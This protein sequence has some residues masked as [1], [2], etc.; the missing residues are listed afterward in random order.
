MPKCDDV[1]KDA[2]TRPAVGVQQMGVRILLLGAFGLASAKLL[3]ATVPEKAP[4]ES[5]VPHLHVHAH[6]EPMVDTA[7]WQIT[8]TVVSNGATAVVISNFLAPSVAA[9]WHATLNATWA[10]AS[11]CRS[12]QSECVAALASGVDGGRCSWLYTTNSHGGN[13]K[14]RSV[15]TRAERREEVTRMYQA[16]SF[17]YSK[18]ELTASHA[19]YHAVGDMMNTHSVRV[20][21]ARAMWPEHAS[22]DTAADHL[23]NI[24]D[25]FITAFDDG[26]FLSTHNDGSSGSLAWVLHLSRD[27]NPTSGGELRFNAG[28]PNTPQSRGTIDFSPGFN[29]MLLFLTRPGNTP[30]EVLPV[31]LASTDAEPRFGL[32]GWYMTSGDAFQGGTAAE[33]AQMKAGE[34]KVSLRG[35]DLCV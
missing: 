33:F 9:H 22:A 6:H 2:S 21:V 24:S 11:P 3:H 14:L 25:Y 30:H 29:K 26:D 31:K 23:R 5:L 10:S 20:A 8:R 34:S 17:A 16:G 12:D 4:L 18:W 27:W 19:L 32:T 7:Q 15:W 13:K 35:D 1:A 28:A